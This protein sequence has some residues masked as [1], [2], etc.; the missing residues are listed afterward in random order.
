MEGSALIKRR[1]IMSN[2]LSNGK[3]KY[4]S[5][6]C[7]SGK[8]EYIYDYITINR[9]KN[10]LVVMP[11]KILI[12]KFSER[13]NVEDF[14]IVV[15]DEEKYMSKLPQI[16][17]LLSGGIGRVIFCTDKLFYKINTSLLEPWTIFVDDCV[18]FCT[19][20]SRNKSKVDNI[21]EV[22]KKMFLVEDFQEIDSDPNSVLNSTYYSY[23]LTSVSNISDD[24]TKA[25]EEYK[26]I[27]QYH[28]RGIH[29]DTFDRSTEKLYIYGCYNLTK[30]ENLNIT[31]LA[32]KFEDTLLYKFYRNSFTRISIPLLKG[33][34]MNRL[35][36]NYF[37]DSTN[38]LSKEK[39]KDAERTRLIQDYINTNVSNYYWT[40][41][42]NTKYFQSDF[43]LNG[44]FLTPNQRGRNDLTH[45]T[46]CVF[47]AAMNPSSDTL[48]HYYDIWGFSASDIKRQW[49]LEMF[50]QFVFRGV[51][52]NPKS[53]EEMNVYVFDKIAL[54]L[55]EGCRTNH[56]NLGVLGAKSAGAKQTIP[57]GYDMRL[58]KTFIEWNRNNRD[59]PDYMAK[60]GRWIS[61]KEKGV[62]SI[63]VLNQLA[64]YSKGTYR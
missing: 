38:G 21:E 42:G 58:H 26:E 55:F 18:D 23:T 43:I 49:E 35:V 28:E 64:D 32:N 60:L 6:H 8:S 63:E 37:V 10:V 7:G 62:L 24:L 47:M 45:Y 44:E 22:Y 4:I 17:L 51:I 19:V 30:Y 2:Y 25:Y 57:D 3:L 13:F 12:E 39:M 54:P 11:T 50:Y 34:D 61:K 1:N 5:G 9:T 14:H 15:S 20:I 31:F 36:V 59:M 41:N 53:T 27:E 56:I 52:R 40:K 46:S 29:K 33:S 16:E 48:K